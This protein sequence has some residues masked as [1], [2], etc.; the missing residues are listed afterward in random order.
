M[1]SMLIN[2]IPCLQMR[3]VTHW[4]RIF[5]HVLLAMFIKSLAGKLSSWEAGL[6]QN[7][8]KVHLQTV[9][10]VLP[11]SFSPL[12]IICSCVY[13]ITK[14]NWVLQEFL[15]TLPTCCG[16]IHAVYLYFSELLIN[17]FKSFLGFWKSSPR[18][19]WLTCSLHICLFNW[20]LELSWGLTLYLLYLNLFKGPLTLSFQPCGKI[21]I[22][23]RLLAFPT[24][25]IQ[26][27]LSRKFS[28]LKRHNL[29]KLYQ[30]SCLSS[31]LFFF[32]L[33]EKKLLTSHAN[34]QDLSPHIAKTG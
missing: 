14:L 33:K 11:P 13:P 6:I 21:I 15:T 2:P 16:Q 8:L 12:S 19:N 9:R 31:H 4:P 3:W 20:F 5:A 7:S 27:I 10:Y 23:S 25:N 22:K 28:R 18:S 34:S 1:L 24:A 29:L 32:L 17:V 30:V 26:L